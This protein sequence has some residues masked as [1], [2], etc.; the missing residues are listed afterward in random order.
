VFEFTNISMILFVTSGI[1]LIA[2]II[3]WQRRKSRTGLYLALGLSAVTWWT[4]AAGFD[5]AAIS[6]ALKVFFAKWEYT[7][8]NFAFLFLTLFSLSFAGYGSWL[9][10]TSV[11]VFLGFITIS[12]ILLAWTNDWHGW[13][14]SGFTTRLFL[15]TERGIFGQP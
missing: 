12:N 11:K 14:W 4:L 2:A 7:A 13:L 5:Y 15:S 1:N 8:Y 6:I 10:K 3:S 9:K